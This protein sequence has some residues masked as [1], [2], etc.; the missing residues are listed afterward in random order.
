MKKYMYE[1]KAQSVHGVQKKVI[2]EISGEMPS[3]LI[4]I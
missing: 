4:N 3:I 1:H 2:L